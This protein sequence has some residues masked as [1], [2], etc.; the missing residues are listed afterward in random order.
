[1]TRTVGLQL[2]QKSLQTIQFHVICT[3]RSRF[4]L[5]GYSNKAEYEI[6]KLRASISSLTYQCLQNLRG[7]KREFNVLQSAKCQALAIYL[8]NLIKN[9]NSRQCS[10]CLNRTFSAQKGRHLGKLVRFHFDDMAVQHQ[11]RLSKNIRLSLYLLSLSLLYSISYIRC[12]TMQASNISCGRCVYTKKQFDD[13]T[14]RNTLFF[15]VFR[16]R[17]KQKCFVPQI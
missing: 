15:F 1:M 14:I 13:F 4:L 5:F 8:S 6:C 11:Q 16:L 10:S 7:R 17:N 3:C 2:P 9:F 12:N